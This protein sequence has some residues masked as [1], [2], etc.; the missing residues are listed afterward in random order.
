L[1]AAHRKSSSGPTACSISCNSRSSSQPN[2]GASQRLPSAHAIA[3]SSFAATRVQEAAIQRSN[4]CGPLI[5]QPT[6]EAIAACAA[7][8]GGLNS[9]A[10]GRPPSAHEDAHE[11]HHH[12][13]RSIQRQHGCSPISINSAQTV[14]NR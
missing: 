14:G 4:S 12:M 10:A 6:A 7:A 3:I 9:A 8:A 13:Q 5:T 2:H 1:P 11:A